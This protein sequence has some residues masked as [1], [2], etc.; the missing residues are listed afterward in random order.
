MTNTALFIENEMRGQNCV[1]SSTH[2]HDDGYSHRYWL[3]VVMDG[4]AVE[5][6]DNYTEY[7]RS[8]LPL[9]HA[10]NTH[11]FAFQLNVR[12]ICMLKVRSIEFVL[13]R[14]VQ[15]MWICGKN[16][17]IPVYTHAKPEE[18][19]GFHIYCSLFPRDRVLH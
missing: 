19:H 16:V 9:L 2:V 18:D 4:L 10:V 3:W 15:C 11:E 12:R 5:L 13:Y 7:R 14:C 1:S 8:K 6:D 17:C